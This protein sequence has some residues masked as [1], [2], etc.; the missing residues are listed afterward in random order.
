MP[1]LFF[2]VFDP[3]RTLPFR[4]VEEKAALPQKPDYLE[5]D[6]DRLQCAIRRHQATIAAESATAMSGDNFTN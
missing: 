4:G 3:C 5:R 6:R 2:A 1:Q